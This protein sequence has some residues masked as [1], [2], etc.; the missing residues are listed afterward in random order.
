[1]E[2]RYFSVNIFNQ[3]GV[4][5]CRRAGRPSPLF[6]LLFPPGEYMMGNMIVKPTVPLTLTMHENANSRHLRP[7]QVF[8]TY[9]FPPFYHG[10]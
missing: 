4:E 8:L 7:R 6:K 10:D 3:F 2:E 5:L 1:M 9:V